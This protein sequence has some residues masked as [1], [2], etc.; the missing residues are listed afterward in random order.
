MARAKH[1]QTS[2]AELVGMTQQAF[3]RRMVGRTS[4]T[5]DELG[6][7]ADV[8]GVPINTLITDEAVAS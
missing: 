5:V 6:R 8:L 2:L 7:I 3:S 1:S 4:F